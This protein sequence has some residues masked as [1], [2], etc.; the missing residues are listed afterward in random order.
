MADTQTAPQAP[1]ELQPIPALDGSVTEAQEALL[2]L[3]DPEEATP[4]TEEAQP[5]EDVESTEETQDESLEEE[6]EEEEEAEEAEEESEEPDEEAEEELLYAVKVDGAEQEVTLD[7]LMKG[8][9][10]QSDYTKKTQE[11]SEDRKAIE[12][13]YHQYNSEINAVQQERQQYI[14]ALSQVVQNS[15]SGLEQY[16]SIDWETLKQEDPIEYLSKRDEIQ[17]RQAQLAANQQDMQQAQ[18]QQNA[19]AQAQR[20]A[21][22]DKFATYHMTQLEEK[23]PEWKDP[24]KKMKIWNDTKEFALSQGYAAEEFDSLLDHRHLLTLIKAKKYDD[25]Q[26]ND[27]P[28]KKI[29]NKPKVVRAGSPREAKASD[30]KK[31]TA[32]MKRLRETGRVDDAFGLF[33]DFVDI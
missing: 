19:Q 17:Q 8:Y 18:Y 15:L 24:D 30:K 5:T 2:G 14:T 7:E 11:L 12:S 26:G 3:M 25:L 33:E 21:R 6:P 27:I 20:E 28:S 16:N 23:L 31:R 29:K 32:Q 10:R 1:A 13:M 4:E 9:S 22:K